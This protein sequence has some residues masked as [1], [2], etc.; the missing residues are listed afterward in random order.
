MLSSPLCRRV[1]NTVGLIVSH[2]SGDKL[3]PNYPLYPLYIVYICIVSRGG[4]SIV[5]HFS[6]NTLKWDTIGFHTTVGH[7]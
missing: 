5:S 7:N 1:L 4:V 3:K 6:G 2:F